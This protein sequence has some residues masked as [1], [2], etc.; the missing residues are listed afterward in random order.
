[1]STR[2]TDALEAL[3][4]DCLSAEEKEAA[5]RA[6][7]DDLRVR[8]EAAVRQ[9]AR[10]WA[11]VRD[12]G[13]WEAFAEPRMEALRR[14]LGTFPEA[15]EG[16]NATVTGSVEGDGLRI[17]NVVFESRRGLPVTANLYWP[18]PL[19]ERMPAILIVHSHHNPRTQ[20]ELQD[21][22]M[23]WAR[24]GCAVLVMDEFGYG[25]RRQHAPGA[26]QDYW[27]RYVNGVQLHLIG[28][29]LMG[30]MVW[31]VMRGVDLLLGHKGVDPEGVV[32]IGAV[33]GGGDPAAVAA[34]LD[35][36]ITCAVPFNFGGP[37]PETVYPLPEDAEDSFDY[38]GRGGW[39][40]TRNLYRSGCDGFL[41][42]AIV[43]SVAPRHLI[44]A[45]EFS[46]D[47]ERDPVWRRLQQVF[48][49]YGAGDRLGF[50]HGKG[51]LSGRPPEA[52]H[53][54]N[55][56]ALHRER[57]YA[58]LER[59][60]K[61][62][63]PAEEYQDRRP[64]EALRALTPELAEKRKFRRTHE[65][66]GETGRAR[67]EA[68]RAQLA[69]LAPGARRQR[70]REAWS[71]LL[72][73]VTPEGDAGVRSLGT[74]TVIG[75][76][77]ERLA[78][79]VEPNVTVPALVLLPRGET[80]R[81]PVVGV[82]QGGKAGFLAHRATEIA[83]LLEAGFPV[84]LPDL[85]G[86]GETCGDPSRAPRSRAS[87]L[88][89]TELMLGQTLLGSRLRDLRSVLRFLRAR[90][91]LKGSQIVLWGDSFAPVNSPGFEDPLMGEADAPV[92][93]E[94]LGGLLALL[95]ALFEDEVCAAVARGM[96][97]GYLAALVETF[98]YLP[99][100]VVAPGALRAG[101][102]CDVAAA[103]APTPLRLEG[104]VDGRN[105]PVDEVEAARIYAGAAREYD[106]AGGRFSIAPA[107]AGDIAGWLS[108]SL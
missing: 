93:S 107:A 32:L 57:I 74:E 18:L 38:M 7:E 79:T 1:M 40:S 108:A 68:M 65:V 76:R 89:S 6:L 98:C 88:A 92:P 44:Y 11:G 64:D 67:A 83:G 12:R 55:V 43:A 59:W 20:G 53:C 2:L 50:T 95:G 42:W 96:L 71:A 104:L 14:S 22:G 66:F 54:N 56:G 106:A 94:P 47:R 72:G 25:E 48:G 26:R 103:L 90:S 70:L 5:V 69:G 97:S 46:W 35:S 77:A 51:L 58:L 80:G 60:F 85:R 78:L 9:D 101:D 45:H 63:P 52:S 87:S 100:D 99:Y 82:A 17:E 15:P 28:D 36:R 37:Q 49:F 102:L 62:E 75:V 27:F 10:A 19:R 34:A 41:P 86:T 13:D 39:E 61:I 81:P 84:C 73:N 31:D 24:Q 91:G 105:C 8:V 29:S 30:W 21:M 16:L 3:G 23:V 33:A 4:T